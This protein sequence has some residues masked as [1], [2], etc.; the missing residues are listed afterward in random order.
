MSKEEYKIFWD[1]LIIRGK[2]TYQSPQ[3]MEILVSDYLDSLHNG[4]DSSNSI[5]E[6]TKKVCHHPYA[7][8]PNGKIICATCGIEINFNQT[9]R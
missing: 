9:D 2:A 4:E 8:A 6:L 3:F 7:N 5:N 1:Y